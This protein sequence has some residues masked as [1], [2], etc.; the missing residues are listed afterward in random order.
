MESFV[1]GLLVFLVCF[2]LL[3][4]IKLKETNN[5]NDY[6]EIEDYYYLDEMDKGD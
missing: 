6:P 1:V 5:K 3:N 2:F 4:S